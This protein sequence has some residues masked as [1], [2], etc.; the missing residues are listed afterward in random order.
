MAL[1]E[2]AAGQGH[3]YAMKAL[4][5][6][7]HMREE[8]EQALEW[9]TRAAEAGLPAAMPN[10]A[11]LLDQGVGVAAPDYPAAAYWYRRAADTGRGMA[12]NNLSLMYTNGRGKAWQVMHAS[13]SSVSPQTLVPCVKRIRMTWRVL[14]ARP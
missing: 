7:Y 8:H 3:A 11:S 6:F 4:G 13:S 14:P 10:V 9:F 5:S 12:A 1:L 2:K